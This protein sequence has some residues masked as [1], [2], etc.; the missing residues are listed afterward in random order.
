MLDNTVADL[1]F[2]LILSSARR[3]SELDKYVKEG[4]WKSGD[5]ETLFGRDVH[6]STLGIIGMGIIGEVVAKRAKFGF[7]MKVC[8]HNRNRKKSVERKLGVEYCDLNLLLSKSDFIVLMTPHSEETH[9][10]I[11]FKEFEIMRILPYLSIHLEG[12]P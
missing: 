3:I 5:N 6:D 4:Y 10:L 12:K 8:Y 11:D 2:G 9:H 1:I 7:D